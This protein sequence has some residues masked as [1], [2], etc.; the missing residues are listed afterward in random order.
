MQVARDRATAAF[1]GGI[2][3]RFDTVLAPSIS[4]DA[5]GALPTRTGR[6]G[7]DASLYLTSLRAVPRVRLFDSRRFALEAGVSAG[8]DVVKLSSRARDVGTVP[9]A[10]TRRAQPML[11]PCASALVHAS[12]AIDVVLSGGVDVDLAPRRWVVER[13]PDERPLVELSRARPYAYLG[14]V[15]SVFASQRS[16]EAAQ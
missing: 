10:A 2:G 7:V 5:A 13:G 14:L 12:S 11:G 8:L 4:L 15:W 3:L 1:G 6:E 9:L 16:T